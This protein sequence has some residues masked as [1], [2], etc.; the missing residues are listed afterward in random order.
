M[1]SSFK[2][3]ETEIPRVKEMFYQGST[4]ESTETS[5]LERL[6]TL[7]NQTGQ[8]R[9]D[10]QERPVKYNSQVRDLGDDNYSLNEPLIVSIEEYPGEDTVIASFPEIEVFGDGVTEA[11]ALLNL[12]WAI[13]D[14][15]KEL[16][17]T[18]PDELGD[19]PKSWLSILKKIIKETN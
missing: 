11:E 17:G 12:K 16:L 1:T 10:V 13:L 18:S 9:V 19:L 14:L 3:S 8:L 6:E 7:T 15:Y 5:I 2:R 4:T